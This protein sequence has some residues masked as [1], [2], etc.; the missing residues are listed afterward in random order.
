[1][2]RNVNVVGLEVL[3]AV[4]TKMAVFRLII[5]ATALMMEAIRLSETLADLHQSIRRYNP[6]DSHLMLTRCTFV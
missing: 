1:M 5:M 2:M 3:I 6:E 4:D